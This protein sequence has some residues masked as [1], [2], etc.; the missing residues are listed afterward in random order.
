MR[1]TWS[2]CQTYKDQHRVERGFAFL[3]DPLFLASSVLVKRPERMVAMRLVMALRLLVYRLAE[4][5]LR[6]Q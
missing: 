6:E 2:S 4:R 3:K 5:R 1:S